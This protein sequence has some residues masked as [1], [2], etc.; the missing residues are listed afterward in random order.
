MFTTQCF[1]L[2]A[3]TAADAAG[4]FTVLYGEKSGCE[5]FWTETGSD[6]VL[7][8]APGPVRTQILSGSRLA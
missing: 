8:P 3:A 2:V 1:I 6:S 5:G 7:E 4:S